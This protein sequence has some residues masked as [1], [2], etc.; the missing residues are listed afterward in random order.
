[1]SKIVPQM[2]LLHILHNEYKNTLSVKGLYKGILKRVSR[3]DS[4]FII[5]EIAQ[6]ST[7]LASGFVIFKVLML[8]REELW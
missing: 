5:D 2:I 3:I 8:Q 6:L 1:M 4:G 7:M